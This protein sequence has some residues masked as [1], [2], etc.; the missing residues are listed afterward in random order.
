VPDLQIGLSGLRT[1]QEALEVIGTNLANASTAGYHRQEATIASLVTGSGAGLPVGGSEVTAVRRSI[2]RL[3]EAELLS[4]ETLLAQVEQELLTLETIEGAFGDMDTQAVTDAI[5]NFFAALNELSAQPDSQAY[6]EQA[7]WAANALAWQF[8]TLGEFFSNLEAN[9]QLAAQDAVAQANALTAEI[10]SLNRDIEP[11]ARA[12]SAPNLLLDRRDQAVTELA[13]LVGVTATEATDG[14][15]TVM[16]TAFGTVLVARAGDIELELGRTAD[17]R[18]GVSVKDANH[19]VADVDGGRLGALFALANTVLPEITGRLDDLVAETVHQVNGCHVQGVGPAGAFTSL[20]GWRVSTAALDT[21][22]AWGTALQAGTLYVRVTDANTATTT[23]TAIDVVAA[24]T[25]VTLAAKL[26]GVTGLT[27]SVADSALTIGV[28]DTDRYTF[29]FLPAPVTT[30]QGGWSGT[31]SPTVTGTYAPDQDEVLTCTVLTTGTVGLT[32]GLAV[33]VR[34]AAAEL[35]A[36]LDVGS[37]YAAGDR[38]TVSDDLYAALGA[39]TLTQNDQ[40]TIRALATSDSSGLLAAAGI[41]TFFKGD[42]MLSIEVDD[43][44]MDDP[45]HLATAMG[46]DMTDNL[47]VLRMAA[48]GGEPL[49]A[50]G[51][52]TIA[53]SFRMVVTHVGQRVHSGASRTSALRDALRQLH[54]QRDDLSGVDVNEEAAKMLVFEQMFQAMAKF[55]ATQE[56]TMAALMEL[57]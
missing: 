56:E 11:L 54:T 38:L 19:F 39:G 23:R 20:T 22:D 13:Q 4:R 12:G 1:A 17:S 8:R 57:L 10:A 53:D 52:R 15:E 26:D 28:E 32:D 36:T 7:A 5:D 29:E 35:V 41:N 9:I 43:W 25:L 6:Q 45:T 18:L 49:A 44:V 37:G 40:F 14:S 27:G 51:D 42:A 16:V 50:L 47:N 2:D 46:D 30:V 55:I 34:N 24:D 33:E 3:L 21:W 31:A 48:L